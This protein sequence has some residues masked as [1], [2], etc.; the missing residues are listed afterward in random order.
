MYETSSLRYCIENSKKI[1]PKR[2]EKVFYAMS[3]NH[4]I[5]DWDDLVEWKPNYKHSMYGL[6]KNEV[7]LLEN[8]RKEELRCRKA[9]EMGRIEL[10]TRLISRSPEKMKGEAIRTYNILIA[11]GITNVRLMMAYSND[12][13]RSLKG[14][15]PVR[16]DILRKAK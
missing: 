16:F 3:F 1:E 2:R 10:R 4:G 9:A 13:L 6:R 12:Q 11:N 14:I 7:I 15:G 5:V 8:L